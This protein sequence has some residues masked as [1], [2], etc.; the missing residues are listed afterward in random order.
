MRG[1]VLLELL[2]ALEN[3]LR[4]RADRTS[5]DLL[6]LFDLVAGTSAGGILALG[7]AHRHLSLQECT[8]VFSRLAESAFGE[9]QSYVCVR[10][11][12]NKNDSVL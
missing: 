12:T 7:C 2:L 4:E 1:I 3:K 11:R 8:A 10:F 9:P 5:T 6:S